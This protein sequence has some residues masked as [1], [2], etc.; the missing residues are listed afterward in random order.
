MKALAILRESIYE[1]FEEQRLRIGHYAQ[2][3]NIDVIS[4]DYRVDDNFDNI[5]HALHDVDIVIVTEPT[6]VTSSRNEFDKF[7]KLL[8]RFNVKLVS[9]LE[10]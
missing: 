3:E 4:T 7:M 10:N 9:V 6:R 2:S 8:D 1:N 5:V